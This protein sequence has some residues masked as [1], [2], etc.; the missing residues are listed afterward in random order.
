[1]VSVIKVQ[2]CRFGLR[3]Y[4]PAYLYITDLFMFI[5]KTSCVFL[6]LAIINRHSKRITISGCISPHVV[7]Y[8]KVE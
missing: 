2:C 1:M 7:Y 3:K 5:L 4:P 6:E 8:S